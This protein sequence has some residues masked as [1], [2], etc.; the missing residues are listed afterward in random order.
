MGRLPDRV[1]RHGGSQRTDRG[2]PADQ[3]PP[4]GGTGRV[5]GTGITLLRCAGQTGAEQP[6]Q[7]WFWRW[8]LPVRRHRRHA[9]PMYRGSRDGAG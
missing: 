1:R 7:C 9:E 6:R 4:E 8:M 5:K 3:V 2:D